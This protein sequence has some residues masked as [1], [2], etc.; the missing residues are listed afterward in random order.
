[1]PVSSIDITA[2]SMNTC[3]RLDTVH[4]Q[5]FHRMFPLPY[6]ISNHK[7]LI[8]YQLNK[9]RTFG[10]RRA[11]TFHIMETNKCICL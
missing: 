5:R 10:S 6:S 2:K 4:M 7:I 8:K 11:D 9:K 1:M 3:E